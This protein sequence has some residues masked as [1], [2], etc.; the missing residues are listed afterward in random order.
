MLTNIALFGVNLHI[1][2]LQILCQTVIYG[3]I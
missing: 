2:F 3:H 1:A